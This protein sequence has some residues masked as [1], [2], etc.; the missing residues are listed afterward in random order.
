MFLQLPLHLTCFQ[1]ELLLLLLFIHT[2]CQESIVTISF[3]LV[4]LCVNQPNKKAGQT[5]PNKIYFTHFLKHNLRIMKKKLCPENWTNS[6]TPCALGTVSTCRHRSLRISRVI[7]TNINRKKN[8]CDTVLSHLKRLND[9]RLI[10]LV[11]DFP[12]HFILFA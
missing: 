10:T 9:F 12:V 3:V 1:L 11:S 7:F 5:V 6:V 4:W 2:L 8:F